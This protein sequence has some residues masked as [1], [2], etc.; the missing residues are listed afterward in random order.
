M[1]EVEDVRMLHR[2]EEVKSYKMSLGNI[3]LK[4]TSKKVHPLVREN[5]TRRKYL[6]EEIIKENN[7]QRFR[8]IQFYL[9]IAKSQGAS[10]PYNNSELYVKMHTKEKRTCIDCLG[11]VIELERM[12][13]SLG[14]LSIERESS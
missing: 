2:V 7:S 13:N 4:E 3:V 1:V 6:N 14:W 12:D 9:Y 8:S 10:R 11:R 5:R